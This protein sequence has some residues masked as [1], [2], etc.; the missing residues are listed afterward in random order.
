MNSMGID[1][2][3]LQDQRTDVRAMWGDSVVGSLLLVNPRH[4]NLEMTK[5]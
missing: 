3:I 4:L 1:N 5:M 2:K